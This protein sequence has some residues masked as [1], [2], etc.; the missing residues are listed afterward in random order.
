MR[1]SSKTIFTT[2]A[3]IALAA[4]SSEAPQAAVDEG[5]TDAMMDT[6]ATT[7]TG[8]IVDVAAGNP[9]FSTL[10]TAVTAAELG[11]TLSGEGPFTVFAPTNAAFAK[12][13]PDTLSA[14]L[15]PEMKDDLTGLLTYH[16]VAGEMKAADIVKAITD[17]GGTATLTTVQ[18]ATLKAT[19]DG[20]SVV[21]ED[22]AGGKSTVIM[23]DVDASNGVVHA[24]DTVVMPG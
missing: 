5:S 7:E 6:A 15:T 23:T 4:C 10:V 13:D 20:E 11:A 8:T 12:V 14:L 19:L 21:L 18:G 3:V 24:I 16:V 9:D 17:G 22:G 2:A 1:I